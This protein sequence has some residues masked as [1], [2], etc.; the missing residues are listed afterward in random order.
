MVFALNQHNYAR[1][2]SYFYIDMLN[3]EKKAP[4]AHGGGFLGSLSGQKFTMI[5]MD[6]MT[7]MAINKSSKVIGGL[8]GVTE[9]K[10]AT[11]RWM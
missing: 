8:S 2:L 6:E 5:P 1:N 11:E 7:E 10:S 9:N 3:T 4:Q